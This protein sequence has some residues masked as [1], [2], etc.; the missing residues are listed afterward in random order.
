MAAPEYNELYRN[1]DSEAVNLTSLLYEVHNKIDQSYLNF[2]ILQDRF[3]LM[4]NLC[5]L[6]FFIIG[7]LIIAD[8]FRVALSIQLSGDFFKNITWLVIISDYVGLLYWIS[9][10]RK[11]KHMKQ[12]LEM[13]IN[14]FEEII[15]SA[16]QF[17]DNVKI[18]SYAV[19]AQLKVRL[20]AADTL[21]YKIRNDFPKIELHN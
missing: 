18:N 1:L 13:E 10:K 2:K 8:L 6:S 20:K 17:E 15:S 16:S 12:T 5:L 4:K 11:L 9:N 7:G 21:Y 3:N 14:T 19:R